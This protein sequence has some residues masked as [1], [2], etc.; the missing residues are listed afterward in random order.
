MMASRAITELEAQA[1]ICICAPSHPFPPVRAVREKLDPPEP[2]ID[3]YC[4]LLASDFGTTWRELESG[5]AFAGAGTE[6]L[7][8]YDCVDRF[9]DHT[10]GDRILS[11]CNG[12]TLIKTASHGHTKILVAAELEQIVAEFL[13]RKMPTAAPAH[14]A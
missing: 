13:I 10:E 12:A 6:L 3:R 5:R 1:F 4:E 8:V 2:V 9:V 14:V 11:W 7:L